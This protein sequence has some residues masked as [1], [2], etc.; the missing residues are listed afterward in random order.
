MELFLALSVEAERRELSANSACKHT[1][2]GTHY[3]SLLAI[4]F[5]SSWRAA[6]AL[7]SPV[8]I[9]IRSLLSGQF[10][11]RLEVGPNCRPMCANKRRSPKITPRGSTASHARHQLIGSPGSLSLLATSLFRASGRAGERAS[12]QPSGRRGCQAAPLV[13]LLRHTEA[14]CEGAL[15]CAFRRR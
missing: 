6:F 11:C 15:I 1:N 3:L 12:N 5:S 8:S 10:I 7:S 14:E 13:D 9:S 2:S 4:Q